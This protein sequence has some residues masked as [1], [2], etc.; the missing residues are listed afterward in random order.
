MVG[1]WR[2]VGRPRPSASKAQ[3]GIWDHAG[4]ILLDDVR[5]GFEV[6]QM[7]FGPSELEEGVVVERGI[8]GGLL[9]LTE[10]DEKFERSL[11]KPTSIFNAQRKELITLSD[12][13][14]SE[15][16][17]LLGFTKLGCVA[18]LGGGFPEGTGAGTGASADVGEDLR[19]A[20]GG[21]IGQHHEVRSSRLKAQGPFLLNT[22]SEAKLPHDPSPRMD[23]GVV[24]EG[25][26]GTA[27]RSFA[28]KQMISVAVDGLV[29]QT[30]LD[31]LTGKDEVRE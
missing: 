29:T 30:A 6:G 31:G 9:A 5:D 27:G 19:L 4:C 16:V 21:R 12:G 1:A 18:R 17:V 2:A 7:E 14:G 10:V 26:A 13:L 25:G 23:Y 28:Y 20:T 24:P 3:K 11:A 22:V 15:L 8:A